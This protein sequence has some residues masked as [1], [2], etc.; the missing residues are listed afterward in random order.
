MCGVLPRRL[1]L[2]T[3]PRSAGARQ[4]CGNP[5]RSEGGTR[6]HKKGQVH[7]S[8]VHHRQEAVPRNG[9]G[10]R[11]TFGGVQWLAVQGVLK[12]GERLAVRCLR[13]G[14]CI[15][16]GIAQGAGRSNIFYFIAAFDENNSDEILRV[17]RED[18]LLP[19]EGFN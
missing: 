17:H 5:A 11:L 1:L 10:R 9:Q 4:L 18:S 8:H 13:V 19:G 3:T 7:C 2:E 12:A 16:M 14:I 15:A 6:A